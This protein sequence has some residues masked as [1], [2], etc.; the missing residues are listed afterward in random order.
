M[1]GH[2]YTAGKSGHGHSRAE[3]LSQ[4]QNHFLTTNFLVQE[5]KIA[6]TLLFIIN[7]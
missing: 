3:L 6:L 5:G 7:I 2:F 4:I 1:K